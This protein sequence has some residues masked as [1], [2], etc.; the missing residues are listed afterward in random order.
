M[1]TGCG[2]PHMQHSEPIGAT[3]TTNIRHMWPYMKREMATH[4][5]LLLTTT[6]PAMTMTGIDE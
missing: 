1:P 2:V 4:V 5:V 3:M 6:C